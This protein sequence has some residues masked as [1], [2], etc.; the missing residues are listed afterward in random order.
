MRMPMKARHSVALKTVIA[1]IGVALLSACSGSPTGPSA[2]PKVEGRSS[3]LAPSARS[4]FTGYV[5]AERDSI[6]A[7]TTTG[8]VQTFGPSLPIGQTLPTGFQ[9]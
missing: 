6:G 4:N 2:A 7:I 8:T 9:W 1:A 5:V 3:T